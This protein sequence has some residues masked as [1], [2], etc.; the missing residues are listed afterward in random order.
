MFLNESHKSSSFQS[1]RKK[2]KSSVSRVAQ[3]RC[4][5]VKFAGVKMKD[6]RHEQKKSGTFAQLGDLLNRAKIVKF[7][8]Q[9]INNETDK[10]KLTRK[11]ILNDDELHDIIEE[12]GLVNED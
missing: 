10:V 7:N 6:E 5:P 11:K 4:P 8:K 12:Y 2:R 9:V 3:P 1:P